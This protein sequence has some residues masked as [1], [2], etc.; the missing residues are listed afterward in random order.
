[1]FPLWAHSNSSIAC[2]KSLIT[3]THS[4]NE[5]P[6]FPHQHQQSRPVSQRLCAKI[7]PCFAPAGSCSLIW[8]S[9][10]AATH[11]PNQVPHVRPPQLSLPLN[12]LPFQ[13]RVEQQKIIF[14][15]IWPTLSQ[16]PFRTTARVLY[17]KERLAPANETLT[18]KTAETFRA[19]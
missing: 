4:D 1:M 12:P 10:K 16:S 3:E 8:T 17:P 19:F 18:I 7:Q 15:I 13:F 9:R 2:T 14:H 6:G 11:Q 5:I